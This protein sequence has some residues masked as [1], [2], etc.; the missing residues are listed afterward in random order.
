[1]FNCHLTLVCSHA[2]IGYVEGTLELLD[3]GYLLTLQISSSSFVD[4]KTK[5][6]IH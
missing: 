3:N 2:P 1:M 6:R 5:W 4:A